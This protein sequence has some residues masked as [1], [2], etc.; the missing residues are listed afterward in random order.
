MK[1]PL[2]FL[3]VAGL[4]AGIVACGETNPTSADDDR[5][6]IEARTVEL[7][8]PWS[9]FGNKV[10][11]YGGFGS[12]DDLANMVLANG[13]ETDLHSR[14]LVQWGPYPS[15]V[16]VR[17]SLGENRQDSTL[18][19]IGGYLVARIDTLA[20]TATMPVEI[21]L[22]QV[23]ETWHSPT[24]TWDNLVDTIGDRRSWPASGA[25]TA[26]Q[27]S[28]GM[29]DPVGEADTVMIPL[30][31]AQ[32]AL[33]ADT[34]RGARR[35]A[36]LAMVTPGVRLELQ[37]IRLRLQTRPSVHRDST[38]I[39]TT[40]IQDR[41]FIYTPFVQPPPD[42]IRV[43]GAPAWRTVITFDMPKVLNGPQSVCDAVGCP[44]TLSPARISHA[45]LTLNTKTVEPVAFQPSDS[46]RIDVRAVLVPAR[47][48]KAPLG[49]S[50]LGIL[51]RSIPADG[52]SSSPGREVGI[53]ITE[54]IRGQLADGGPP[55]RALALLS[56]L[57]PLSIAFS[58]FEGPGSAG[59]PSLR[60]IVTLADT[61]EIRR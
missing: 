16:T 17:D 1:R 48:P 53:P 29:W 42:G 49:A 14:G 50:F 43:G 2:F 19:F 35:S 23:T 9:T 7:I 15:I 13:F 33:W 24:T 21:G 12:P 20:S 37:D 60:L 28:T 38:F 11:V 41:T 52:F 54:F 34:T 32:V 30:D 18:T 26:T 31:S 36:R 44:F 39:L 6:V 4:A 5:L 55:T 27:L 59:E 40:T 47:L 61:L 25:G 8:L 10:T 3:A 58:S 51:G 45:S 46:V 22:A 56:T 57:E